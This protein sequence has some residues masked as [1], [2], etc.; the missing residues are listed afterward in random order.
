MK[1]NLMG[2]TGGIEPVEEMETTRES[3]INTEIQWRWN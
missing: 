3:Q 2:N 1:G